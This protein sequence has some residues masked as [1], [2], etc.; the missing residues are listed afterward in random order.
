MNMSEPNWRSM[1]SSIAAAVEMY[2]PPEPNSI[3]IT[4]MISASV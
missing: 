4:I 1:S 3:A 2:R